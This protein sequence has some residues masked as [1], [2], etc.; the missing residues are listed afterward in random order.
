MQVESGNG[1]AYG[2]TYGSNG[3]L[4]GGSEHTSP[5]IISRMSSQYA[6]LQAMTTF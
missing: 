5:C 3:F 2:L 4:T 6:T 1:V